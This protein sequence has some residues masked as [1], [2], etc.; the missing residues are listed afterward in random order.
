MRSREFWD[1]YETVRPMLDKR[2]QS[3]ASMFEYLDRLERPVGIVET[4]CTRQPG[5]WIGDG[6]S[7]VL[8]DRYAGMLARNETR[9]AMQQLGAPTL[10]DLVPAMVR[11]V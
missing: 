10:K 11:R 4:G 3:F 2:S 8:F 5:N 1:Y 7:T 9:A 6:N